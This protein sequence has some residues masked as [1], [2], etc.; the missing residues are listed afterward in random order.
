MNEAD[1]LVEGAAMNNGP[2]YAS[3]E[4]SDFRTPGNRLEEGFD[5]VYHSSLSFLFLAPLEVDT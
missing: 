4:D 5:V 1:E 2:I 3:N